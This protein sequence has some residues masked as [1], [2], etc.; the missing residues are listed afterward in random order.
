MSDSEDPKQPRSRLGGWPVV[1]AVLLLPVA[2]VL[3]TGPVCWLIQRNYLPN[4]ADFVYWPLNALANF[5]PP[6]GRVLHWY[7][8]LWLDQ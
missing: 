8:S 7:I 1:A 3:S 5:C 6:I 4:H 2:Y